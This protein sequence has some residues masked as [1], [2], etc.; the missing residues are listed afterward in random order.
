MRTFIAALLLFTSISFAADTS[1]LISE[2]LD[3]QIKLNIVNQTMPAALQTIT[4]ASEGVP[5][6]VA[7]DVWNLLPWGEQTTINA[8]IEN[9]TLRGAL[10]AI[11]RKLGLTYELKDE[12]VEIQPLP[13]LRRL[14][15]RATIDELAVLDLLARTPYDGKT[16]LRVSE[17]LSTI[18][19]KLESA[20]SDF[21][22]EN[23]AGGEDERTVAVARTA[24]LLD[25]MD[26]I[27]KATG[28]TW[29]PWGKTLVVVPK[30]DQIRNLLSKTV[31]IRFNGTNVSQVLAELQSRAAVRFSFEPGAVQRIPPDAQ[32]IRLV[33][34]NATIEQALE[35]IAG[36]TGLKWA[37][38]DQGVYISN[39]NGPGGAARDNGVA[40]MTLPNGVQV[41]IRESQVPPD[42]R[43]YLKHKTDEHLA[44]I[45]KQMEKEGFK[46]STKPTTAPAQGPQ[47]L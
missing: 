23:R 47:D 44:E 20:K 12:T 45:R 21:A 2:R 8:K 13:A 36:F 25:A 4:Q 27:P 35:N 22:V 11:T 32:T 37:I 7:P 31:T 15:R 34:E 5:I 1:A 9:Q 30:A 46:P 40:L 38:S 14:G 18:D 29:Y 39:P 10:S 43:E 19:K 3:R 33:L 26:A 41:I 28:A 17:L 6:D 42:M 24:N 16:E